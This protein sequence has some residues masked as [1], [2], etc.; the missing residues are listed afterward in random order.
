[1]IE[2]HSFI[3]RKEAAQMMGVRPQSISNYIT[4]GLISAQ[5]RGNLIFI[6]RKSFEDF[7]ASEIGSELKNKEES[8]KR[9]IEEIREEESIYEE[10]KDILCSKI[11]DLKA[12][13]TLLSIANT[14]LFS[15]LILHIAE[16]TFDEDNRRGYVI[17]R[18]L[19][20]SEIGEIARD[21]NLSH[22]RISQFLF[23]AIY[24]MKVNF[25]EIM[26]N[27]KEADTLRKKTVLQH[28]HIERLRKELLS[29]RFR[30]TDADTEEVIKRLK[31]IK[32]IDFLSENDASV[33]TLNTL[34]HI[35]TL[36]DLVT[37]S[38][39]Q[40]RR[41][42]GFGKKSLVELIEILERNGLRLSMYFSSGHTQG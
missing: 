22:T 30:K 2:D 24:Q 29:C 18:I 8:I 12:K 13:G 11:A 31:S 15:S 26:E 25:L 36:F 41:N 21:L 35:P 6:N 27:S 9:L 33:R 17:R 39:E 19:G 10:Q 28:E 42:R 4:R 23:S 34:K 38:P 7:L 20:G 5:K 3:T 37:S 14:K 40:L 32:T 1:M 16:N